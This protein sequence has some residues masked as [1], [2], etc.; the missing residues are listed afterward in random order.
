MS[1]PRQDRLNSIIEGEIP[2]Q[3]DELL[4]KLRQD[5]KVL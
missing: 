2:E 3:V 4:S 1:L 5:E